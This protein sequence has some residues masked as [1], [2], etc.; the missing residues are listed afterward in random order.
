MNQACSNSQMVASSLS[1]GHLEQPICMEEAT[2]HSIHT[3]ELH[4]FLLRMD[5]CLKI[6]PN[7]LLAMKIFAIDRS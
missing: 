5:P 3:N 7:S 2:F 4:Q 1:S 6:I